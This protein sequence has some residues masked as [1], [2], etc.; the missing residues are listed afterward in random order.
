MTTQMMIELIAVLT[1]AWDDVPQVMTIDHGR[2]LPSGPLESAHRSLQAGVRAWVERQTG[3][4][5]GHVEQRTPLP[6]M[7]ACWAQNRAG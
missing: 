7:T 5:I 2:L 3:H 6:I 1:A 4:P